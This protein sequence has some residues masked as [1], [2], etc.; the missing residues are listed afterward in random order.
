MA[1]YESNQ[2]DCLRFKKEVLPGW[3]LEVKQEDQEGQRRS[4]MST[5]KKPVVYTEEELEENLKGGSLVLSAIV[6]DTDRE[7]A[8]QRKLARIKALKRK[9]FEEEKR[10]KEEEEQ[11]AKKAALIELAK[12]GPPKKTRKKPVDKEPSELPRE[13]QD[14]Q[15]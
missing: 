6:E 2:I 3:G 10:R 8:K 9:K 1:G 7:E 11:Q 13:S 12:A 14:Q 15:Q 5:Q 4:A